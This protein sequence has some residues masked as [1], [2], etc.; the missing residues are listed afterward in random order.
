[1]DVVLECGLCGFVEGT[2]S[3]DGLSTFYYFNFSK[4]PAKLEIPYVIT[5]VGSRK[6]VK[7]SSL[8]SFCGNMFFRMFVDLTFFERFGVY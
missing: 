8:F 1:M 6:L 7:T 2:K 3:I 5:L 4:P